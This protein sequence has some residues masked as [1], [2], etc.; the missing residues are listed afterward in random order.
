[1]YKFS[2][3]TKQIE[4]MSAWVMDLPLPADT[5]TGAS[6]GRFTFSFTPTNLGLVTTVTDELTGT[7]LDLTD[8][9]MW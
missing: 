6:G 2:L 3:D 8:Y 4:Q 7:K 5:Y 9:D 1:M